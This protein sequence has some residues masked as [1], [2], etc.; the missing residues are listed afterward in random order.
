MD[1]IEKFLPYV[2]EDPNR[3]YP[4]VKNSVELRLAKKYNSTVNT[5]QSLRLATLGSASIGRDGSVKVAVSAGT[6]ALQGKISVEERKLERLVEI[7]REIE[8]ILEQHGAQTTHDLREAKANHENTIRSGPVKAWDLF[9][10]VRGQGKVRPEE[11]R[12]NWLPSDLAQLEEYK[13]QEDKLRAEIEASQ[14][15]LKPLNEALA[16]IDTLTAEVDST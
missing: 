16:K 15:A 4:I 3:L 11:I 10:L 5:L 7:A 2:N 8:G 12:T 1:I 6:E 14:S 9:N 13:I